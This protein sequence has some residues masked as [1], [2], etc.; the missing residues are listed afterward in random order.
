MAAIVHFL[1]VFV[2]T[3]MPAFGVRAATDELMTE[4]VLGAPDA[5]VTIVEYSS[6]TCPHCADFHIHTLPKL[7]AA[8]IDTGKVRFIFRDFPLDPRALSAAMV[9]RCVEPNRYFGF[10]EILFRDQETWAI[11]DDPVRELKVRAKLAQLSEAAFNACLA[12]E[13]LAKAITDKAKQA[14]EQEGVRST[15]I[16]FIGDRTLRGAYPFEDFKTIIDA[17][18]DGA[19][20]PA[21][22]KPDPGQGEGIFSRM[23]EAVKRWWRSE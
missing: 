13:E 4:R 8:Y 1:A 3:L 14:H 23:G 12:N 21:P 22:Q 11:S 2:V 19:A 10:L 18:L 15:P 20:S 6:L 5:P 7:K 9:A 16:F 17:A